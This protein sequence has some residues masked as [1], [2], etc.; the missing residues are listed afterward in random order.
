MK[1]HQR[2]FEVLSKDEALLNHFIGVR[3]GNNEYIENVAKGNAKVLKA[4][5]EDAEFFYQ[6]DVKVSIQDYVE[7][8]KH[9]TFHEKNW[10]NL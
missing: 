5:L 6:E 7:K 8:L 2:Y 3:N 4:R 1:E 9:V 10:F